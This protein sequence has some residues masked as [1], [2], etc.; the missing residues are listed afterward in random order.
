M[1]ESP[2]GI[3]SARE[4]FTETIMYECLANP[5]YIIGFAYAVSSCVS[6]NDLIQI[7]ILYEQT[8]QFAK[9]TDNK[10]LLN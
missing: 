3:K 1:T 9:Q 6:L 10:N 7:G 4:K 2:F 5:E 8:K